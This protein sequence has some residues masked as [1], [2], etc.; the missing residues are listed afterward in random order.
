M[1]NPGTAPLSILMTLRDEDGTAAGTVSLTLQSRQQ[2]ARFLTELF[3]PAAIG[4]AFRGS[5]VIQSSAPVTTVGLHF[6]RTEFTTIAASGG[7]ATAAASN[8]IVFPQFAVSGG[9]ATTLGMVNTSANTI[10]GRVEVFDPAGTPMNVTLNG[11]TRSTF[12]FQIS[13]RGAMMLA[14]R[15]V[16]G[17]S[18]F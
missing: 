7:P 16:N 14:P 15:D 2:L 1:A 4:A 18:P 10:S 8:T 17:Q 13:P 3:S 11:V 12:A 6:A 9:W 5:L